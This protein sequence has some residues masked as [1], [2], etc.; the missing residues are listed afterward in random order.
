MA[1]GIRT[2]GQVGLDR[3]A[4]RGNMSKTVPVAGSEEA[5]GSRSPSP[6]SGQPEIEGSNEMF[7]ELELK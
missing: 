3:N 6:A 4:K 5:V 2:E 1:E 7:H